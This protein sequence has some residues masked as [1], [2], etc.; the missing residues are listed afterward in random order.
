[1]RGAPTRSGPAAFAAATGPDARAELGRIRRFS[2]GITAGLWQVLG[3]TL[4][5]GERETHNDVEAFTGIGFYGRPRATDRA[6]VVVVFP[7]DGASE[8]LIVGARN[9]DTQPA[10]EEDETA[11]FN[12]SA[13]AHVTAAGKVEAKS[14]GG[15]AGA[16][17][18]VVDL[19]RII[20]A[21]TTAAAAQ[22]V[23]NPPGAAA[24]EAFKT[25]L[26]GLVPPWPAGTSVFRAE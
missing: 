17:A 1:M 10:L 13:I 26:E 3:H 16:V 22:S 19:E 5:D 23:G 12:S 20:T 14:K 9:M 11:M 21:L 24:L 2:L 25:A 15:T 6:E 8:P 7:G 4:L 18:T